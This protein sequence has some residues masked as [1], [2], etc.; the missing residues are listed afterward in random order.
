MDTTL[1]K[2]KLAERLLEITTDIRL[3]DKS[4]IL[5]IYTDEIERLGKSVLEA[6][7]ILEEIQKKNTTV[8]KM[9]KDK[10]NKYRAPQRTYS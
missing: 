3:L 2:H 1:Y 9:I 5:L 7:E 8:A 4:I 10:R 6:S